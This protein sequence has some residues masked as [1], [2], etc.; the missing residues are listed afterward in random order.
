MN[1]EIAEYLRILYLSYF[2]NNHFKDCMH[3]F[4]AHRFAC[5]HENG[6]FTFR[7]GSKLLSSDPY[8]NNNPNIQVVS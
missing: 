3:N 1:I 7:D 8:Q 6:L 5:S 2:S 4:V